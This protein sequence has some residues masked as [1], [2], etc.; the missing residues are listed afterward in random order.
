M[1]DKLDFIEKF[2]NEFLDVE[3]IEFNADTKFR[4]LDS[5]DSLTGMAIIVMLEDNY[6]LKLTVDKFEKTNTVG[7]IYNHLVELKNN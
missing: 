6:N 4:D 5:W 2:K 7:E 1:I 3:D